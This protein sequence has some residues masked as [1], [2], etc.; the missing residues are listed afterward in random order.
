MTLKPFHWLSLLLV[1]F[2]V[3][4]PGWVRSAPATLQ[5]QE[6]KGEVVDEKGR[7]IAGAVCTLTGTRPGVLPDRGISKTTGETGQFSFSGLFP[8]TYDVVCAAVGFEPVAQEGLEVTTQGVSQLQVVLPAEI[9]LH[10]RVEVREKA[11]TISQQPTAPPAKLTARQLEVLPLAEQKFKA[12]LPLV[13][14]VIRTPD[15][16]ISIKGMVETQGMLLVD[17]AETVDPVTGSFSIEV[18]F[19]AIESLEVHKTAYQAGYGRF[20]GGLTTIQTK[21]PA[22]DRWQF[23][24]NDF[25]PTLRIKNGHIVGI[26]DDEPRLRLTGPLWPGHL[27]FLESAIYSLVKQPVRGLA[28]P[29][30]E[31]KT[32]SFN[33]LTEF[34]YIF[35]SR[36]LANVNVNL[37]PLRRQ[38]ANINSLTPQSAASDYGQRGVAV[39]VLDRFL[40]ASG[41]VV[42]GLF[43]YTQFD[44]YAHGQGP[45]DLLVTPG[46]LDGNYFNAW[47]RNSDQQE[48]MLTYQLPRMQ[49]WGKHELKAGGDFVHR[50]YEGT[51]RS[52]PVLVLRADNS[53]AERIDFTGPASLAAADTELASFV[54]DHWTVNEHLVLDAGLRT[55]D[56]TLGTS[57][58]LAPR[59]GLAYSPGEGGKTVFR[60]GIGVFYDRVPLLAGDFSRNPTR[61]ITFFGPQGEPLGPPLSFRNAYLRR[62][63]KGEEIVPPGQDL[64]STPSNLTWNVELD[65]QLLPLVALRLSYI[66]SRTYDQFFID[67]RRGPGTDPA[68]V[69][70]NT[71]GLRYH[72]FEATLRLRASEWADMNVSYVRSLARGDLN[73]LTDI[74]VPFERP[75]IRPN[76]FADL[77]TNIPHRLVTWGRLKLPR[78]M[79]ASPLLDVHSGFPY[80]NLDELQNYVGAPNSRRFPLFVSLDVRFTKDFRVPVMSWLKKHKFRIDFTI[81][82]ITNHA[83]P[84]D[85]YSNVASPFF[86]SFAGF[87]HRLYDL[88]FDIVY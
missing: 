2:P 20:S 79:T 34:Q 42:T 83:N 47:S 50:S 81:F 32:Q 22:S 39:G 48:I 77:G 33:S 67:P 49:G 1:L 61:V 19:D 78:E 25:I 31:I 40:L 28:F 10:E 84:R 71:G 35:S 45:K 27:N 70:T 46:G 75:V 15:G 80:S 53:L 60:S 26:A 3:V 64:E 36:H 85:V 12:A 4:N 86:G 11:P 29:H 17:S 16:R 55:S 21:P 24:L 72:E 59:F 30:N 44:S 18:P 65:Q 7:P 69:L 56:Q 76:L 66:S 5:T 68:L 62:S 57:L 54:Q 41:G 88:S 23:E 51:S 9:V 87:Q 8:G 73:T 14:G 6:L 13:P 74:Y 82:N 43:Q 63:E 58:A 37:F 38:F 52:Q